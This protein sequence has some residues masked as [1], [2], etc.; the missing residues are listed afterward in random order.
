MLQAAWAYIKFDKFNLSEQEYYDKMEINF[1][2]QIEVP[3][4]LHFQ[5]IINYT[6][7]DIIATYINVCD[8]YH[9]LK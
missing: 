5:S 9:S 7:D 1:R 8:N 6:R 2:K 3:A 4:D